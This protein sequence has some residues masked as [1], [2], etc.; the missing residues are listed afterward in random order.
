MAYSVDDVIQPALRGV[1]RQS[2]WELVRLLDADIEPVTTDEAKTHLRGLEGITADDD[3][4]DT[5]I[6]TARN[7]V[8]D[9]SGHVLIEQTWQLRFL[10][11]HFNE[12]KLR[13]API[14][15]V[16]SFVYDAAGVATT[17]AAS[18]YDL[19]GALSRWP[20]VI[21]SY[22]GVWPG[23]TF[24]P[25]AVIQFRAGYADRTGSPTEGAEKVPVLFKHAIKLW[26]AHLYAFRG[27]EGKQV[28][29]PMAVQ[30]LLRRHRAELG[31]A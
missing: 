22:G 1:D 23:S 14:I 31:F 9:Y 24:D 2:S 20:R 12:I 8:E 13:R 27:D 5:L 29:P 10:G 30:A 21:P 4:I 17:L 19:D 28:E 26:I 16:Q 3:Y 11:Y 6:A 25:P 15:A 7:L 18:N